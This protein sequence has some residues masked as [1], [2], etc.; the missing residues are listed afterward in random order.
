MRLGRCVRHTRP[1]GWFG[2]GDADGHPGAARRIRNGRVTA[3]AVRVDFGRQAVAFH[4]IHRS[5]AFERLD[6]HFVQNGR[7]YAIKVI[8]STL[9]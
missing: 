4:R 1:G 8:L 7:I 6:S 9:D 3:V 5:F 2:L